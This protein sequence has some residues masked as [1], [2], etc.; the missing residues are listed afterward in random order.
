MISEFSLRMSSTY[1][2]VARCRLLG[3]PVVLFWF[4]GYNM[5]R[6]LA[7]PDQRTRRRQERRAAHADRPCPVFQ[8]E[9]LAQRHLPRGQR[10]A[11]AA[12]RPGMELPLQPAHRPDLADFVL[13][14]AVAQPT[15]TYR[16]LIDG[17]QPEGALTALTG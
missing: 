2:L 15:I 3:A 1:E 4:H 9:N 6:G 14:R 8:R 7:T 13:Q 17:L 16:Q 11:P 12:L 10:Q 5:G